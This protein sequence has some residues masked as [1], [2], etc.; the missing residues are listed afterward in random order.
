MKPNAHSV[1]MFR[2]DINMFTHHPI[3]YRE[4]AKARRLCRFPKVA[5]YAEAAAP[6]APPNQIMTEVSANE[7]P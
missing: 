7:R 4:L 1:T 6:I 2:S 5:R 3:E